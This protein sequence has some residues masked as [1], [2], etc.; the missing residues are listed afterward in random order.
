MEENEDRLTQQI[1]EDPGLCELCCTITLRRL[2]NTLLPPN[3]PDFEHLNLMVRDED[4]EHA[5]RLCALVV[6]AINST[7]NSDDFRT[8][9]GMFAM[10]LHM[11]SQQAHKAIL[12]RSWE[13]PPEDAFRGL[14]PSIRLFADS[15]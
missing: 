4:E 3:S 11:D 8:N 10:R 13:D 5:C 7:A 15:G 14:G 9:N 1:L 6:D 2:R 12:R